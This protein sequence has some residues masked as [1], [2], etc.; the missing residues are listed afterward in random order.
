[1]SCRT[2]MILLLVGM[3]A[4]ACK[5][6]PKVIEADANTGATDGS[7]VFQEP[8]AHNHTGQ[9]QEMSD[10]VHQVVVQEI[11]NTD[12]Y[13]YLRVTEEKEEK[14]IAI[15]RRDIKKGGTYFYRGG[16]LKQHFQSNEFN[17]V[18]ETLYLV[19]DFWGGEEGAATASPATATAESPTGVIS[20]AAGAVSI[21]NLVANLQ[22]YQGK[23]VAVTGKC[24]KINPMIMGRNWLHIQDGTGKDL[25]LT[26]TTNEM[27]PIGSVVTLEGTFALNKDFGAGYRYDY[28]LEGAVV[29]K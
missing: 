10:A 3:T 17:R 26:V 20:P 13:T 24:V 21:A 19:G 28:I 5:S 8:A 12:K 15:T 27:V 6:K 18:F 22:R 9:T 25:E 7:S 23:K 2:Y 29:K 11:L 4:I 16:L 14:W 1:M